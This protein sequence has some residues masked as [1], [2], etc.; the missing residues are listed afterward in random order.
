MVKEREGKKGKGKFV[1]YIK[2]KLWWT[3][4]KFGGNIILQGK[5][6]KTKHRTK[7]TNIII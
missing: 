7:D 5:R 4:M 6:K 1:L 3:T 2:P